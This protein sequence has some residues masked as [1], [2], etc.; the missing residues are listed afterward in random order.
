MISNRE[1]CDYLAVKTLS[2]LLGGITFKHYG[3]CYC[4]NYLYS[5]R[6]KKEHESHKRICE[7][8]IF[9]I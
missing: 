3:D 5:F 4:L 9:V 8:E 7:K 2:A 6:T 1:E